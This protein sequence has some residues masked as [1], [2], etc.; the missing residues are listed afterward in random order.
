MNACERVCL[1]GFEL[2]QARVRTSACGESRRNEDGKEEED[3][4][5]YTH[6]NNSVGAISLLVCVVVGD[7]IEVLGSRRGKTAASI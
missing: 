5:K 7:R 6:T 2:V 3:R 1:C 4:N